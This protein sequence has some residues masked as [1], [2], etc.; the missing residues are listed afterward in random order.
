[1]MTIQ[2]VRWLWEERIPVLC[3]N[4]IVPLRRLAVIELEQPAES[5]MTL[6]RAVSTDILHFRERFLVT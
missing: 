2:P 3:E 6:Y 4:S 1:M 5:L